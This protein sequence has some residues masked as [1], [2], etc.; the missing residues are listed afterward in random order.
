MKNRTWKKIA[1][2][3]NGRFRFVLAVSGGCLLGQGPLVI[4]LMRDTA[5]GGALIVAGTMLIV[6]AG[7]PLPLTRPWTRR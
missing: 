1:R 5:L 3:W 7:I 6:M 4:T 2:A